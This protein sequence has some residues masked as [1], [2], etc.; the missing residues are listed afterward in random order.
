M[1]SAHAEEA[2][3]LQISEENHRQT[4]SFWNSVKGLLTKQVQEVTVYLLVT[5]AVLRM[6]SCS[7]KLSVWDKTILEASRLL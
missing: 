1:A 2:E 3:R 5:Y 6:L 7:I 4:N